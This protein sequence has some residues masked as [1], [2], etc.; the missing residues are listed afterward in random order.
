MLVVSAKE[1]SALRQRVTIEVKDKVSVVRPH[2]NRSRRDG[3]EPRLL[4]QEDFAAREPAD[5]D[6]HGIT[7]RLSL[8]LGSD[9]RE[10]LRQMCRHIHL[11][12]SNSTNPLGSTFCRLSCARSPAPII[13]QTRKPANGSPEWRF[14]ANYFVA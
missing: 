9:C 2:V 5:V 6:R 1:P 11:L 7:A 13:N 8:Q 10:R 3:T 4:Q 12:C 14:S